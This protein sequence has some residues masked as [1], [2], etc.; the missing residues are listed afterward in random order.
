[1]RP[2]PRSSQHRAHRRPRPAEPARPG[3]LTAA[4]LHLLKGTD[5]KLPLAVIE[6]EVRAGDDVTVA[7]LPGGI[8]PALPPG[9]TIHHLGSDLSYSL[10][11]ALIIVSARC[12]TR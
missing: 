2:P 1:R 9:V 11:L 4:V 12:T 7:L 6:Q 10:L 5:V 8:A 3:L